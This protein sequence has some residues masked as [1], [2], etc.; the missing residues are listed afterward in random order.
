MPDD[1]LDNAY[2]INGP[3]EARALHGKWAQTYDDSF[4]QG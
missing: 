1:D 3:E 2:D 4:G